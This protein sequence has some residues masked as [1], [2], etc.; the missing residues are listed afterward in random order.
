[1]SEDDDDDDKERI[2]YGRPPKQ[3]QFKKGQ[4]GNPGGRPKKRA[5]TELDLGAL[6]KPVTVNVGGQSREMQPKELELRRLLDKAIKG[7]DLRAIDYLLK[8]F[9]D[10]GAIEPP[11]RGRTHG[12]VR[13][14]NDIPY[15]VAMAAFV[16]HGPPPWKA[17]ILAPIKAE[18]LATRSEADR[19]YDEFVRYDL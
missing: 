4:S 9:A 11:K 8:E 14:P 12:V 18:Y 5:A 17:R 15:D 1:M 7:Q 2:G 13:L 16:R 3:S 10:Y 6:L 19:I